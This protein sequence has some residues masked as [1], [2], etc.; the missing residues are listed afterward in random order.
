MRAEFKDIPGLGYGTFRAKPK[1]RFP[2]LDQPKTM[3]TGPQTMENE[4]LAVTIM[5]NGTLDMRDKRTGQSYTNQGYFRDSGDKGN[6]WNLA[7]PACDSVYT[8]LNEGARVVLVSDGE[9][10]TS[11]EITIDWALPDGISRD[12]MRRSDTL[13]PYRIVTTITMRKGQPWLEFETE[14]DNTVGYHYLQVCF[15]SGLCEAQTVMAQGQFDVVE[16]PIATP[17]YAEFDERPQ[18]EQPMNSFVD[19][20]DGDAGLALLNYGLKAYTA[21]DDAERTM[22]LTLLRCYP[23]RIIVTYDMIDYDKTDKG[24]QCIGKQSFRY[25]VMPHAGDWAQGKVW[26]AADRITLAPRAVQVGP[27]KHGTA[28]RS[29]SFLELEPDT[30]HVSAIKQSESGEGWIV[31]LFNPFE[32]TVAG[33]IRLNGGYAGPGAVQSP[34][35]RVQAEFALPEGLREMWSTVREVNLEEVPPGELSVDEDGWVSVELGKTKILTV[36]FVA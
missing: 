27:T 29:K 25:G 10:E 24:S 22:G 4:F 17:N 33:R 6:P 18:S 5:A 28:P 7:P 30:L 21:Y 3:L 32:E 35:E 14:V 15:A 1:R 26:Q 11:F 20:S 13:K 16:R 19:I 12:E 23:L 8:T 31:R 9:L 36:E 34:V 2:I